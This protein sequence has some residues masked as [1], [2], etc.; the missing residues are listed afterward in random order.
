MNIP[1]QHSLRRSSPESLDLLAI[2]W[3]YRLALL[4]TIGSK[5]AAN[6]GAQLSP[7]YQRV[8]E[9]LGKLRYQDSGS[10][11]PE[12]QIIP[13]FT[14]RRTSLISH[15]TTATPIP[16]A[17]RTIKKYDMETEY[18]P[19]EKR[20]RRIFQWVSTLPHRGVTCNADRQSCRIKPKMIQV[21][22]ERNGD[23]SVLRALFPDNLRTDAYPAAPG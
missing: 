13:I 17:E 8:L 11:F 16:K 7:D 6:G 14:F 23:P 9:R 19:I 22:S 10:Y 5:N 4:G 18:N 20:Q 1:G 3:M 15:A 12:S 2:V 21:L